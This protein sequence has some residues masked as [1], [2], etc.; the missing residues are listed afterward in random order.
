MATF[1]NDFAFKVAKTANVSQINQQCY[2]KC[3][4]CLS[5]NFE[6]ILLYHKPS[7]CKVWILIFSLA[8]THLNDDRRFLSL[9]K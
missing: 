7:L 9:P 1:S 2:N 3:S 5:G 8:D 4:K 6:M